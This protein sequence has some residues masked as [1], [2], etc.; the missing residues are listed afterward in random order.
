MGPSSS[1]KTAGR[2]I[3]RYSD[4]AVHVSDFGKPT[5]PEDKWEAC[6]WYAT[7]KL[8]ADVSPLFPYINAVLDDALQYD[9]PNHIRFVL[10]GH[11]CFLY[12]ESVSAYFFEDRQQ[13]EGFAGHLVDF[14]NDLHARTGSI[15]PNYE[16]ITP[17]PIFDVL[18]ILPRTNCGDCGFRSCM[19]F[20]AALRKGRTRPD[21]CPGLEEP[22]YEKAIY[23]IYDPEGRL[24]STVSIDIDTARLKEDLKKQ[25][26]YIHSLEESLEHLARVREEEPV[27]EEEGPGCRYGLTG[28]ELEV[29]KLVAE[30][31]TN[32]EISTML[33][34]SPHT[35][36]SHVIHI[37]NKLGVNDRTQAAVMATRNNII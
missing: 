15:T 32:T 18:K 6:L 7:F 4:F 22:M 24:V 12:P 36:K 28:R 23:P 14:L 20:A 2:L 33:F 3:G 8:N 35:V 1:D 27:E 30:G 17:L 16:K 34:I 21:R 31:Y 10:D 26:E 19:S 37:F 5:S 9:Q 29:L 13:A 11:R 25:Q